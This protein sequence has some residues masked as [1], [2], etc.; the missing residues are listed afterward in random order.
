MK[1]IVNGDCREVAA[2]TLADALA[3]LEYAGDWLATAVNGNVVPA[4]ERRACPLV[5][6]DCIEI[7]APMKGG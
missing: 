5:E 3:E 7:L 6:G 4:R 1:L 2:R